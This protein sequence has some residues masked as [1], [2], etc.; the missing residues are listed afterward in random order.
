MDNYFAT[1]TN[2]TEQFQT[3]EGESHQEQPKCDFSCP[4]GKPECDGC[5]MC[6]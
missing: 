2:Q 1:Q 6:H 3:P 5:R 4:Y